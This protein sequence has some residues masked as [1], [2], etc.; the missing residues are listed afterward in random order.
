MSSVPKIFLKHLNKLE[1]DAQFT[2]SSPRLKSSSGASYY[3]KIGAASEHAQYTAEAESLKAL[4][5]AA[6]G[7]VPA[8][9]ASGFST[10]DGEESKAGTGRPYFLSQYK[11]LRSL[12]SASAS[13]LGRRLAQEVHSYKGMNGFGFHVPTY[14]GPTRMENGWYPSWD[15]CYDALIAGLLSDL[16]SSRYSA[17]R[18]KGEQIRKRYVSL[19]PKPRRRPSII[20]RISQSHSCAFGP[21]QADNT[22]SD[23]PR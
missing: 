14:C 22:T 10:Q 16:T 21:G 20:L 4:D 12:S 11:D 15:K 19:I 8:V 1:P 5:T 3:A 13:I 23:H 7:L 9:L 17:L 6:P 18:T 2:F